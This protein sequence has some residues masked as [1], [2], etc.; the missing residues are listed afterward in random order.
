M[1]TP[2]NI[3][4]VLSLS[5]GL[6]H[7][8]LHLITIFNIED[9]PNSWSLSERGIFLCLHFI[10]S[11]S[12]LNALNIFFNIKYIPIF[13]LFMHFI[14]KVSIVLCYSY[15]KQYTQRSKFHHIAQLFLFAQFALLKPYLC[16]YGETC[17]SMQCS[18]FSACGQDLWIISMLY[19]L[20]IPNH[21]NN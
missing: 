4:S 16:M 9:V 15:N 10:S 8:R 6:F 21:F 14:T 7:S 17:H 13:V 18:Q 12:Q 2:H 20:H 19:L 5:S 11:F 1:S 3:F